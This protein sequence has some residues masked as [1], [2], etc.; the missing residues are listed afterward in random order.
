[1]QDIG[2]LE[3]QSVDAA[4]KADW[5]TAIRLNEAILAIDKKNEQALLR[6]A[7]A[8]MQ[9]GSYELAK[10]TYHRALRVQPKLAVAKQYLERI[11]VLEKGKSKP[12]S[13]KPAFDPD[14]FIETLGKTKS[15]ALS[16]LGQKQVLAGLYIGEPVILKIKKRRVEVR[17]TTDEYIG[18]LPDDLSKR[19]ILFIKA[20]SIYTAYIK[21]ASFTKVV[22]F[23]REDKKG[24]N[25]SHHLSFPLNIQKNID[26]ITNNENVPQKNAEEAD[27]EEESE[28]VSDWEKLVAEATEEKEDLL[29]IHPDDVDDDEDE[30]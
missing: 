1:M 23:I 18:T 2:R 26:Q 15:A 25:V 4:I 3:T 30:E 29:A 16:N 9:D 28:D 19:L 27:D 24:R 6:L 13:T 12:Q 7:Y 17:S 14:L 20:K 11:E 10:K 21:D 5:G 22:I 8:Y